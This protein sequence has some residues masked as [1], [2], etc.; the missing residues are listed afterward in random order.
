M[1]ESRD[2]RHPDIF[3]VSEAVSYLRLDAACPTTDAAHRRLNELCREGQ[4]NPITLGKTRVYHRADLDQFV[5][6]LVISVSETEGNGRVPTSK[7]RFPTDGTPD[8]TQP[9]RKAQRTP[10][11]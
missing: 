4:L 5:A 10:P 9:R 3:T 1:D 11:G 2:E 6:S 8:G 7:Q